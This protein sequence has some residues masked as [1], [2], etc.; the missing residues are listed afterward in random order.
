M[1][2]HSI[3]LN[4]RK[5]KFPAKTAFG[6]K[7]FSQPSDVRFAC[8]NSRF[9]STEH[10]LSIGAFRFGFGSREGRWKCPAISRDLSR[11]SW[12]FSTEKGSK[13]TRQPTPH[14]SARAPCWKLE[15]AFQSPE[16]AQ[17]FGNHDLVANRVFWEYPQWSPGSVWHCGFSKWTHN[18]SIMNLSVAEREGIPCDRDWLS[19][20]NKDLEMTCWG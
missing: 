19:L 15:T 5:S 1:N 13:P 3:R 9:W 12:S 11:K 8:L 7:R 14:C 18:L 4:H 20:I 6:K 17:R 16:R 2:S 10:K